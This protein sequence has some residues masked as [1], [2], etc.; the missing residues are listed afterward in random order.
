MDILNT[1]AKTFRLEGAVLSIRILSFFLILFTD[2]LDTSC[3]SP[4]YTRREMPWDLHQDDL[5]FCLHRNWFRL[6]KMTIGATAFF[7]AGLVTILFPGLKLFPTLVLFC[8]FQQKKFTELVVRH[9][10]LILLNDPNYKI[11]FEGNKIN[12]HLL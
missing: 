8:P 12:N 9:H 7:C 11:N 2:S 6:T 4:Y 5:F 10:L 1:I 3:L